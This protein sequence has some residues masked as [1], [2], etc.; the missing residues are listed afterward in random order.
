MKK[1]VRLTESDLIKLVKRVIKEQSDTTYK[2]KIYNSD[3]S[4]IKFSGEEMTLEYL[5]NVDY[6]NTTLV[7]FKI[8]NWEDEFLLFDCETGFSY[9][10][11]KIEIDC[12]CS[13]YGQTRLEQDV[14]DAI[15]SKY[16]PLPI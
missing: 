6:K 3:R 5:K 1:V 16:C 7:K 10:K 4:K 8:T 2:T 9:V 13:T 11:P 12:T 15:R 14:E